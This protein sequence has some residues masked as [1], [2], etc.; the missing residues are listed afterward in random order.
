MKFRPCIDLHQGKVKQIVGGSL[1]D[2]GAKENFVSGQ[3]ADYYAKLY[4]D[5]ELTGGHII[6]LGQGNQEQIEK[7]LSSYLGGMQVG[8][9][10]NGDNAKQYIDMGAT[11]VI[12]T[13]YIFNDGQL[14]MDHLEEMKALVG[15]EHLVLDL[16]CRK[17]DGRYYVVTNR[18]QQFTDFEINEENIKFLEGYCDEFLVHAVDVEGLQSGID[19]QLLELLAKWVKI[20]CTY[21]GGISS[22]EDIERIGEMGHDRID[23][24]V[25]SAL[26]IFGGQ[27]SFDAI[28]KYK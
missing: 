12:V 22:M 7:A 28:S 16:S 25:G 5:H 17:R 10:I 24:T 27:L 21:A 19:D 3:N 6:A 13:S 14:H 1:N 18:W 15:K 9:G 8:G 11:H 2:Q 4:L 23:F 26:D 20:P